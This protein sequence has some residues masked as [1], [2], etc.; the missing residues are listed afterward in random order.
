MVHAVLWQGTAEGEQQRSQL[1]TLLASEGMTAS[2]TPRFRHPIL[3]VLATSV[4][5]GDHDMAYLTR[6]SFKVEPR[7]KI[8]RSRWAERALSLRIGQPHFNKEA[9]RP[10]LH[11]RG[12]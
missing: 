2:G 4:Q 1:Q 5:E 3:R 8:G 7:P 11:H 10:P 12:L 9:V 6:K